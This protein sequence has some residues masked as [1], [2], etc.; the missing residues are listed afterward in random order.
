MNRSSFS[1]GPAFLTWNGVTIQLTA[2]WKAETEI[3]TKDRSTNLRGRVGAWEDYSLTKITARPVVTSA[4]LATLITK[5]F[6]YKPSMVGQLI[7]PGTDLPAVIQTKDGRSITFAAAALTKMPDVTFA[8]GEDLFGDFELTC[9]IENEADASSDDTHAVEASSTYTEPSF[10]PLTIIAAR[11]TF[12][13]GETAPFDDIET[14]EKGVSLKPSVTFEELQTQRDGLLNMRIKE[15]TSE[16]SFLPVNLDS[17]DF[18]DLIK[19][20]GSSAGRGKPMGSRGLAFTATPL[21]SGAGRPSLSVPL[22]VPTKGANQF[23]SGPRVGEVTLAC[24]QKSVTGTIS[25]LFTLSA[26]A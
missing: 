14:D 26:T 4:N 13:W 8:P 10:D 22:A 6:P 9:L 17:E 18:W 5:L 2:D 12:A 1:G 20:Q 3:K 23:G 24:E 7:F 19:P 21:G 15:V 16:L 11:Y 25:D